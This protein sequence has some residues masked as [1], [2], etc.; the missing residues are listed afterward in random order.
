MTTE[1]KKLFV[2]NELKT[3]VYE[4]AMCIQ[5]D[6]GYPSACLIGNIIEHLG[7]DFDNFEDKT[8]HCI[9]KMGNLDWYI[10]DN[11][12]DISVKVA[13]FFK[14]TG[15]IANSDE[16]MQDTIMVQ[17][18]GRINN[19]RLYKYNI[20]VLDAFLVELAKVA[21]C[22]EYVYEGVVS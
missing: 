3:I 4:A 18:K 8:K 16:K 5:H 19:D 7:K 20:I 12:D 2:F 6:L 14:T 13:K 17:H 11:P 21:G 1:E 22:Y 10:S 9:E 15:R